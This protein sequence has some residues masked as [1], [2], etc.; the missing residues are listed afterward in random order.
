MRFTPNTVDFK[1]NTAIDLYRYIKASIT[2]SSI[3]VLRL[4]YILSPKLHNHEYIMHARVGGDS[5][6]QEQ[7][8][9]ADRCLGPS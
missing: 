2:S 7:Q 9:V 3:V 6:P 8:A 4:Q 1:S 5:H